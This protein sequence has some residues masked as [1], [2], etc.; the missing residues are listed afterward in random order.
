[1]KAHL[2]QGSGE[3]GFYSD[4]TQRLALRQVRLSSDLPAGEQPGLN[5]CGLR[6]PATGP[7]CRP[8]ANRQD[9]FLLRP[10]GAV[11]LCQVRLGG[12]VME[13]C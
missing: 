3:L 6:A 10:A 13:Q 9:A 2:P 5:D 4:P 11:S 12:P 7:G 8:K 1:M